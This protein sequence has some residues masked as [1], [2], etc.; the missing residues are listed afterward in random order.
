MSEPAMWAGYERSAELWRSGP[1]L[2]Y[3]CFARALVGAAP[4]P[5]RG[6]RV[7]DLGAGTGAVSAELRAAGALALA[8]D[9]SPAML[10]TARRC[11]E[12]LEVVAADAVRLPFRRHSYDGSFSGFLL[13]HVP[14]PHRV[15]AEA[16]RVTRPG[17]V[18]MAMTFGAGDKHPAKVAVDQV[19]ARWGW[20]APAWYRAQTAWAAL[21][22]T[23]AGLARQAA[24]A[25]L[26]GAE[27]RSVEAD[28]GL[29]SAEELIGWRLGHAHMAGFASALPAADL[30]RFVAEAGGVIGPGP[31]PLRRELLIL[32]SRLPA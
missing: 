18:L 6:L 29:F 27:V 23:A 13:N 32:S 26:S 9:A 3:R 14:E 28:A 30:R 22:D 19:A 21:T 4:L 5:L 31:Q 20:E 8:V 7:L 24:D 11:L 2:V 15:L 10:A 16:A 17:G 12:G 1:E 25:G